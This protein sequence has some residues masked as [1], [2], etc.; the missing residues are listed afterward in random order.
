[1]CECILK[2]YLVKKRRK[3]KTKQEKCDLILWFLVA[4]AAVFIFSYRSVCSLLLSLHADRAVPYPTW[5]RLVLAGECLFGF[6][7]TG[8]EVVGVN[9]HFC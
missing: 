5:D 7:L 3:K 8:L 6:K 9:G 2:L 4:L 1:M